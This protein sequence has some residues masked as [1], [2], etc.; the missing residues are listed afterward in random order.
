MLL[1]ESIPILRV[2]GSCGY[3]HLGIL[4]GDCFYLFSIDLVESFVAL[5]MML[6]D[7]A[8]RLMLICLIS[9]IRQA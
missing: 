3:L 9:S 1:G 7:V 6:I 8:A 5:G 4:S 2:F